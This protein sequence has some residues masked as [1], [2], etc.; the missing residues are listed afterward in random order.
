FPVEGEARL[1]HDG[2]GERA[3]SEV[4]VRH[5]GE[6]ERIGA[7]RSR[8]VSH[9]GSYPIVAC[10]GNTTVDPAPAAVKPRFSISP[11]CRVR[12]DSVHVALSNRHG[13][14]AVM[15]SVALDFD[16]STVPDPTYFRH[17]TVRLL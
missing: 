7:E 10:T 6:A 11:S 13:L 5:D 15:L 3:A 8:P 17:V 4:H 2:L 9:S 1:V 12:A 16:T 14:R